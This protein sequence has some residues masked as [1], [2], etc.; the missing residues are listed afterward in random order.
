MKKRGYIL[1]WDMSLEYTPVIL[2]GGSGSRMF[3]WS[4]DNM[5]KQFLRIMGE[6]SLLQETI[7]RFTRAGEIYL[8]SNVKHE[9][10]LFFQL[11][12][13]R[14][15][16]LIG[17]GVKISVI[18]EPVSKNTAPPVGYVCS[19]LRGRNLLFLPCD[20]V[21]DDSVLLG[22]IEGARGSSAAITTIGKQPTGPETGFGYLL[23]DEESSRVVKF[24]EKPTKEVAEGYLATGKYFWN[25]GI[26]LMKSDE[27]KALMEAFLPVT[28]A[29]IGRVTVERKMNMGMQV[30]TLGVGEYDRC[31]NI[32]IDYGLMEKLPERSIGMLKYVGRWDDIGSFSSVHSVLGEVK[33]LKRLDE[34]S[35]NCYVHASKLV[36]LCHVKD[37]VV[38]DTADALL[39]S[40]LGHS[41][42]VKKLYEKVK[43]S[44]MKEIEYTNLVYYGWGFVEVLSM[45]GKFKVS[46]VTVYPGGHLE[47]EGVTVGQMKHWTVLEGV[48]R[49]VNR[50]SLIDIKLNDNVKIDTS[51]K[52]SAFN[53][54]KENLILLEN[55][56]QLV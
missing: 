30:L 56:V 5:P 21:Y 10:I 19:L 34:K 2:C 35:E 4:R 52:H 11:K 41:Q 37:L 32:S 22:V 43:R 55:V 49:V 31:E 8:V 1:L 26:F 16:G 9:H 39:I 36:L 51:F 6:L 17:D 18:L 14:D 7:L 45:E 20:H 53:S 40:D 3:P 54:G 44:G 47:V 48:G 46:K 29:A 50:L 12:E 38:V 25:S 23:Y 13:L 42:D 33:S 27:V 24:I 15:K 28:M